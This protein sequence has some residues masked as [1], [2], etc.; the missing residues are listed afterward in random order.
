M[1]TTQEKKNAHAYENTPHIQT[2]TNADK[3]K[4]KKKKKTHTHTQRN[5]INIPTHTTYR[6]TKKNMQ[7]KKKTNLQ[8]KQTAHV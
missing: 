8:T 7:P 5:N 1:H 3:K 6:H 2:E 4:N